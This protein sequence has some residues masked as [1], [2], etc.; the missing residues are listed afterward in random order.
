[1]SMVFVLTVTV[2]Y[3]N[4][5]L[6]KK[7]SLIRIRKTVRL[8]FAGTCIYHTYEQTSTRT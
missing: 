3:K 5:H 1:M 2:F 6:A 4:S 8:L 7:K